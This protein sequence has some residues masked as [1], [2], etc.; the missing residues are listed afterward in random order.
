M[1]SLTWWRHI[2]RRNVMTK[3]IRFDPQRMPTLFSPLII[4]I[5][6]HW[7]EV[8][9]F[10]FDKIRVPSLTTNKQDRHHTSYSSFGI[11]Q[12]RDGRP[13][14]KKNHLFLFNR[15][16]LIATHNETNLFHAVNFTKATDYTQF[17]LSLHVS[18]HRWSEKS[19]FVTINASNLWQMA[20]CEIDNER[21]EFV[22]LMIGD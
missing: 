14:I 9:S 21:K 11:N 15:L 8:F 18:F 13:L 5:F 7:Q 4:I 22:L 2:L 6:Y 19:S 12:I 1:V 3:T 16:E 10:F 20:K 17:V